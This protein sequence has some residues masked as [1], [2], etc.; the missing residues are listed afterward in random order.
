MS[1]NYMKEVAQLLGVELEERF[2]IENATCNPCYINENGLYDCDDDCRNG[3][4]VYLLTGEREIKKPILTE[5]EREYLASVIAPKQIYEN[6]DYIAKNQEGK[7]FRI[8][9]IDNQGVRS[10]LPCFTNDNM[11]KGM[12]I[13]TIYTLK[14]LGL[15]KDES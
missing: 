6:V 8:V 13:G 14:E 7:Y 15:S 3:L 5:K 10:H 4:L 2:E 11:Y 12:E 9:I 1:K